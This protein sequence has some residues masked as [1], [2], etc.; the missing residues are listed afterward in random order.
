MPIDRSMLRRLL[1]AR[2][3]R[4]FVLSL[5]GFCLQ[6]PFLAQAARAPQGD[7]PTWR[8]DAQLTAYQPLPAA[9]KRA[10]TVLAKYSLGSVSGTPTWADLTGRGSAHEVLVLARARLTAYDEN[11]KQLWQR[12]PQGYV[13]AKVEWVEDL[14]GDGHN[15][16][17]LLAGHMGGTRQAYLIL[18]GR[19][20]LQKAAIEISTG[21][22][23]WRGHCG[24][25]LPHQPG[26]QILI[27]TS[28]R[29]A[30][31]GPP[32][33]FGQFQLWSF[34]GRRAVPRWKITP[35]EHAIEYPSSLIADLDHSGHTHLVVDSWCHVWNIDLATGHLD[36]HTTW[37][38]Q[39]ANQRH[40]GWNEL[41]DVDGDAKLDFVNLSLTKHVDVLRNVDGKLQLAWTRG[42]PDPVTTEARSLRPPSDPVADLD[43]DGRLEL[44][45]ALFD[46]LTDKRWHLFV[47][48]AATGTQKAE[49]LDLVPLASVP[50]G[51]AGAGRALLCVR[52]SRIQYDPPE[53]YEVWRLRDG[54]LEKIWSSTSAAFRLEAADSDERRALYFSALNVKRAV[55]SDVDGDGWPEFFTTSQNGSGL[56]AWGL[57]A[58]EAII[59]KTGQPP[60]PK[61]AL[62]LPAQIPPLQGNTVPYLL[63]AD[64]DGAGQNEVLLYDN[65]NVTALRLHDTSLRKLRT[66]PSTEVPVVCD[67]LGDGRPCLLTAG[68]G[69]DGN[70]W[71]QATAPDEKTL[72]RF[73]F[74]DS[75]ACGQYSERPHYFT[76]GHFT[77]GR[78]FDV[79]TYSTKP[80]ARAYV[81]DGRT[82]TPIWQRDELSKIER[83]FQPFGGRGAVWD[84]NRDGADDLLFCNPDF[85]CVANGRTGE[86]LVGPV[87]LAPLT[88]CW[89]AYASPAVLTTLM[90]P[91][92]IYLGGAYSSRVTISVDGNRSLWSEYLPTDRWPLAIGSYRFTEGLL[93][94]AGRRPWRAAQVEADGALVCFEVASGKHLWKMSLPTAPSGIISGDITGRGQPEFLFGGDDG[95]LYLVRDAGNHGQV[96]W[97]KQFNAPVGTPILADVNADGKSEIVVSVADGFV[98]V[99]H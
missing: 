32:A 98:Y 43:G 88:K 42:W 35:K 92:L 83:H 55:T 64:L 72:W 65:Q 23:S 45:A 75:A 8:H 73:V 13:P 68:R 71:V 33:S 28:M 91:P 66:V 61:P 12:A 82:G 86:L 7:W 93:P 46:G 77:G 9:I 56:Q 57:N 95:N 21:D 97:R 50:I 53:S 85:Y 59:A 34:D 67:L 80:A 3:T 74:P 79:F 60:L 2:S 14:D 90:E 99:L 76:V 52:S 16:I 41:V 37:D 24:A 11:G 30:Q 22:F 5:A 54:S 27:I 38:P 47:W 63:A 40:Y 17:V 70:L 69:A 10:P 19:T 49:A 1:S 89:P 25:Y 94:P 20:G 26:K 18:D 44:T 48:D 78:H 15:E 29:Q 36:S 84:Y 31:S 62:N 6:T 58:A 87:N 81:L 39:G 4:T 96:V 51:G